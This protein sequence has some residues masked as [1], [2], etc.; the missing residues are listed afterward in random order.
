MS[1]VL[2]GFPIYSDSSPLYSPSLSGGS[3]LAALPLANLQS[4]YVHR[5]ARSS[6]DAVAD[7]V[8]TLDAGVARSVRVLSLVNHNLSSA[9]KVRFRGVSSLPALE[10]TAVGTGAF[11]SGWT[12]TGTPTR[13]ADAVT[14]SDGITL[15]TLG[16]DAAGAAEGK[17]RNVTFTGNAVKTITFRVKKDT[18]TAAIVFLRDDTAVADRLR[19]EITW[20]GT[21]PV[22][23]FSTG[24]LVSSTLI[25]DGVYRIVVATTSVTA[26]NT[27]VLGF[28]P[29]Y[30]AASSVALTGT[31]HFGDVFAWDSATDALVYDTGRVD[32]LPSGTD[33]ESRD[34]WLATWTHVTSAAQSARYWRCNIDDT[35]NA[36]TYVEI[37]RLVIAGGFQPTVNASY[38]ATLGYTDPHS[39]HDDADGGATIHGA[40][41]RRRTCDLLCEL[42]SESEAF[43]TPFEMAQRLGTTGQ[44]FF[45]FDPADTTYLHKRSFLATLRELS[46]IEFPHPTYHSTPFRLMEE[47]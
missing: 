8:F 22:L 4:R 20:S 9:G 37:G 35:T 40:K 45:V 38:G 28:F 36:D 7:T 41:P 30:N 44:L 2:F 15:D 16:D 12:D 13:V 33:A 5:V 47:L 29:A 19:V 43:G 32:A 34:G 21:V 14:S 26:A 39:T 27:N 18:S 6:T 24:S 10:S 23:A 25:A 1:N 42:M 11:A 17:Q 46:P 31:T 3:W